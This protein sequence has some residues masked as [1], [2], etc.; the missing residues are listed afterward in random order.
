MDRIRFHGARHDGPKGARNGACK[1]ELHTAEAV[2]K[3]RAVAAV[4]RRGGK[5]SGGAK[6]YGH[7]RTKAQRRPFGGSGA[8]CR[9]LSGIGCAKKHT[10]R[11][12]PTWSRR[13]SRC[14]EFLLT[15]ARLQARCLH[16]G[17]L[18]SLLAG[19]AL[20]Q[21]QPIACGSDGPIPPR[22]GNIVF[23]G[24]SVS[25][26]IGASAG[27]HLDAQF[28]RALGRLVRLWNAALGGRP[29]SDCL[30][31][32]TTSVGPHFALGARFNLIVFHAGDNDIA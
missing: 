30:R 31:L 13:S 26:R 23:D 5:G 8:G 2:A 7:H 9:S 12:Q 32:I 27:R 28:V 10:Q 16:L 22:C 19:P 21:N 24:D 17:L 4:V 29:V 6:G 20:A 25:V 14:A 15:W 11:T 1:R 3:R 18:F